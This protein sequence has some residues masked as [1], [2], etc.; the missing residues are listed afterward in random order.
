ME[1]NM[2]TELERIIKDSSTTT[3][4]NGETYSNQNLKLVRNIDKAETIHFND[5]SSLVSM[6]KVELD[7]FTKPLFINIKSESV[8]DVITGMDK[9]KE[10][11]IPYSAH[12]I[13]RKFR[14]GYFYSYEDFIIA[15]RSQFVQNT[16]SAELLELLKKVTSGSSVETSDDGI[17]QRVTTEKGMSLNSSILAT[18]IRELSP[19]RT[20]NEVRQPKSEFLF[21]IRDNQFALFEADGG[22]WQKEAKE[23]IREFFME[24][25]ADEIEKGDVVVVS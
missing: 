4:I 12:C 22:A 8:V 24:S 2:I 10:R 1:E 13:D 21:R 7:L 3:E 23:N 11:E 18:P 17:T 19:F 20:F 25:L 9:F 5:L 6:I 16:D 15:I 14:Y